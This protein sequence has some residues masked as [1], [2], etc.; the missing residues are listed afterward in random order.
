MFSRCSRRIIVV[1]TIAVVVG[2]T[3]IGSRLYEQPRALSA[4]EVPIVF[5]HWRTP[6]PE[7]R[8]ISNAVTK[9]KMR[10]LFIRA[11]Q[12]DLRGDT[13]IQRIRPMSGSYP[14]ASVEM[15]LVYNATSKLLREFEQVDP[16][17]IA[18]SV[19]GTYREDLKRANKD[20]ANVLGMQLDFDIPTRL[21]PRYAD[22]LQALRADLPPDTQLSITGLPSWVASNDLHTVLRAVDFWIPQ[23]YGS[24]IPATID[25]KIPISSGSDVARHVARVRQLGHPFYAG[26]SAYGYAILYGKDGSLLE[27]RANIDPQ[28]ATRDSDLELVESTAYPNSDEQR[29]V[30]RV[31]GEHVFRGLTVR[32]GETLVF[33]LPNVNSLKAAARAVRENAGEQ[34]LGICVFRL[35]SGFDKTNLSID[36]VTAA[37]TSE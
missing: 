8:D 29:M 22:L 14:S 6:A 23:F 13:A 25:R 15:H 2:L 18:K 33:D 10:T 12:F 26:I 16:A 19:E 5:W 36:E 37:L 4:D 9:A 3:S 24:E 28:L 31:R 35:P 20:R 32:A 21:L 7:A 1:L 30:Y 17:V 27:V 34:L 11:G